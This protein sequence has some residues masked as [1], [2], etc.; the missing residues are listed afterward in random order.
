MICENDGDRCHRNFCAKTATSLINLPKSRDVIAPLDPAVLLHT[1]KR[2]WHENATKT[3][4]CKFDSLLY[5]VWHMY[6]DGYDMSTPVIL[7]PASIIQFGLKMHYL[8]IEGLEG[9]ATSWQNI[10]S[11]PI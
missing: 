8:D 4:G 7:R 2:S 3:K 10:H 11:P 5:C 9:M 1:D 6:G